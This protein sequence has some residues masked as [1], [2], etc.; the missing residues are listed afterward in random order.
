MNRALAR[1]TLFENDAD[2]RYFFSLLAQQVRKGRLEV[3]AFSLMLTHFHLLVRSPKGELSEAMRQIQYRYSRRFNRTRRRD[4][5]LFRGRFL[6]CPIQDLAYRRNVLTYIH[7]NPV[8]AGVAAHPHLHPWSSAIHLARSK[9]PGWLTTDWV[10]SELEARG[11][12]ETRAD[13]LA[14]AFPSRIDEDFRSWVEKKLSERYFVEEED[15][16]L[17]Y[18]GSPKVVRWTIRKARLADGTRPWQPVSAPGLV[19]RL[20]GKARKRVGPL[21]GR[22]AR[23]TK[24]A[25]CTLRAGLLRL[26]AGCTHHE[27]G[28]RTGRHSATISRDVRDHRHLI[29]RDPEYDAL[30]NRLAHVVLSATR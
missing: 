4:G 17:R 15:V 24:D 14:S 10:D 6:S 5:T 3:H 25:W 29:A 22:F 2:R 23:H 26:L 21:L 9:R 18:A 28:L 8:D 30:A 13:R 1:R 12:G 16:S 7:D 27:I 11:K 20:L 19:E